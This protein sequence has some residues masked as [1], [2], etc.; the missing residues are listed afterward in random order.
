MKQDKRYG[1]AVLGCGTVG[2]GTAKI[3]VEDND[4]LRK[5]TNIPLFLKY[6][7]DVKFDHAKALGLPENL[8]EKDFDKVLKDPEVDIVVEL[9]GGTTLAKDFIIKALNAGKNVVTANK[10]L[11]A[12]YGR[13]LF[14]VARKNG[15]V[16]GFEASCGGGI[17]IIRALYDGL[18]A[19]RNEALFGIVN[20][21]CNY[22]LTQMTQNGKTYAEALAEAQRDG[23]AEANP[24]LDVSGLDSAHKLVIMSSLAFGKHV[25]LE[26]TPV[27]GIDTLDLSDVM[28][29]QELGYTIK[30]IAMAKKSTDGRISTI[31]CPAFIDKK[32]P[33]AWVSGA[34]NAVS[35][36]G[37][38]VG[39]TMYYGRGAGASP[40]ASAVTSDIISI[41]SGATEKFFNTYPIW[42]DNLPDA[43]MLPYGLSEEK[44]YIRFNVLDKPGVLAKV[45]AIF[46]K[47]NIS[48][49]SVVQKNEKKEE[50]SIPIVIITHYALE[51][52]IADALKE[53]SFLDELSGN[54]VCIR[55]MEEHKEKF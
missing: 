11:L 29:G 36:Y 49:A 37:H 8:Y 35:V 2:G 45:T 41:L 32:H 47:H 15:V 26:S 9:I 40:T 42:L 25:S 16:I 10:A 46:A 22:I 23:L 13:E 14:A 27:I 38:A 17:P 53:I 1:I 5:R 34:F 44:F 4:F 52:D 39:H 18:L 55:I 6:I 31:V 30:L 12:H 43:D 50:H 48:I 19:N 20:G 24:T 3:L 7:V 21:T 51:G 54:T 33:L 28:A